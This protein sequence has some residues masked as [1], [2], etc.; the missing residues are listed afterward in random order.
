MWG[1]GG[2]VSAFDTNAGSEPIALCGHYTELFWMGRLHCACPQLVCL[3]HGCTGPALQYL[4]D[5]LAVSTRLPQGDY[6]ESSGHHVPP[7]SR[8]CTGAG[9]LFADPCWSHVAC[10]DTL[11]HFAHGKCHHQQGSCMQVQNQLN[12]FIVLA[13][14]LWCVLAAVTMILQEHSHAGCCDSA[15][16]C[17]QLL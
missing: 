5:I 17:T 8:H 12:A 1:M 14:F 6:P 2:G 7:S 9:A 13:A 3:L 11:L 15:L 10:A 16:V 4:D